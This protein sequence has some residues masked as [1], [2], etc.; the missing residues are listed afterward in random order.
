MFFHQLT[1]FVCRATR[2]RLPSF[3]CFE[4]LLPVRY[5]VAKGLTSFYVILNKAQL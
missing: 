4:L 2:C 3:H 1:P 5:L